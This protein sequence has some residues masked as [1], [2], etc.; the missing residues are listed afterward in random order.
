MKKQALGRGLGA[1]IDIEPQ[2]AVGS[3]I[4]SEV[5]INYIH[6]N[7]NQPRT[8]FDPEAIDELAASIRVNG[9]ISPI[10]LR[11]ISED[12]YQIIAGERRY[13]ASQI[14]G[15]DKI[16]AYIRN[17]DDDQVL[18]LALIENIQ[19][20][21]LNAIEIALTYNNLAQSLGL[22]QDALAERVGKKRATV[23]NY[24]RLLKLPAEIQLGLKNKIIDMGHAR[25]I[26]GI[27]DPKLQLSAYE[28]AVAEAASV[29]RTEEIARNIV[30]GAGSS[31]QG[32][33]KSSQQKNN[34]AFKS[35]EYDSLCNAL[36]SILS[37]KVKLSY[38]DKGSGK[39]SIPFSSDDDLLRIMAMFDKIK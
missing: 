13:R 11:K 4:F 22:T 31:E 18:E 2:A 37:A 6:P 39:I 15:L 27:E 28:Q 20:E 5:D 34:S 25:A 33:T 7:P 38:T 1:L 14:A 30:N 19:R 35:E 12:N 36:Q 23:A 21:D 32:T 26:A 16:P 10:T 8:D 9:I 29:R 24:L 3:T 17:V